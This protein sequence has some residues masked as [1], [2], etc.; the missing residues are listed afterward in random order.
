MAVSELNL[1]E[2][3][4]YT[5]TATVEGAARKFQIFAAVPDS[6][7]TPAGNAVEI[8]LQGQ[9]TEGGF[10]GSYDPLLIVFI[11]LA[12]IFAAEWGV[13]CYEKRQLR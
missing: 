10:D 12:V 13:Y 6:E 11:C 1:T 4:T 7:R 2:T 8:S 3:G 9:A 5:I